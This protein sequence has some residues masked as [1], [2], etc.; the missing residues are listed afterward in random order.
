MAW[1]AAGCEVGAG[2]AAC[3]AAWA[4]GC[5]VARVAAAECVAAEAVA[6]VNDR[7]CPNR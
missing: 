7:Q 6:C 4:A 3:V 5:E 2:V 1:V